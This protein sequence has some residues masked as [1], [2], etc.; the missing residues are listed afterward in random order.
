MLKM[1]SVNFF[2]S[3]RVLQCSDAVFWS[4]EEHPVCKKYCQNSSLKVII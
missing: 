2:R 4:E 1:Y 3:F